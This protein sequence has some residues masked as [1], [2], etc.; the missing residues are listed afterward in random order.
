MNYLDY[1]K[2]VKI[3]FKDELY[4]MPISEDIIP[5]DILNSVEGQKAIFMI[6]PM[7]YDGISNKRLDSHDFIDVFQ[8]F[9]YKKDFLYNCFPVIK[10]AAP[11]FFEKEIFIAP[12]LELYKKTGNFEKATSIHSY[13]EHL[14]HEKIDDPQIIKAFSNPNHNYLHVLL[15][16]MSPVVKDTLNYCDINPASVAFFPLKARQD[17]MVALEVVKS[18]NADNI[19]RFSFDIHCDPEIQSHYAQYFIKHYGK[20][21]KSCFSEMSSIDSLD[22]VLSFIEK[23]SFS[24][25]E[26]VFDNYFFNFFIFL[27]KETKSDLGFIKNLKNHF[28]YDFIYHIWDCLPENLKMNPE[29]FD[30]ALLKQDRNTNILFEFIHHAYI[31]HS[32][33]FNTDVVFDYLLKYYDDYNPDIFETQVLLNNP[34]FFKLY[35]DFLHTN[36]FSNHGVIEENLNDILKY[37]CIKYQEQRMYDDISNSVPHHKVKGVKF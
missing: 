7:T 29:I 3:F 13:I 17:K 21:I 18:S 25:K 30:N 16:L 23:Y 11:I 14:S 9:P 32:L 12:V 5:L 24:E 31:D 22:K 37:V 8:T 10:R 2:R 1:A 15:P 36:K 6:S 19:T 35:K 34:M 27:P 4:Y 26:S 20:E 33:V 28:G